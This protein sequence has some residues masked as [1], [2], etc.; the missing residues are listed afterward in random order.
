MSYVL[1]IKD[2]K[3]VIRSIQKMKGLKNIELEIGGQDMQSLV[4]QIESSPVLRLLPPKDDEKLDQFRKGLEGTAKKELIAGSALYPLVEFSVS[5]SAF[6]TKADPDSLYDRFAG[7]ILSITETFLNLMNRGNKKATQILANAD[8]HY[9]ELRNQ[10]KQIEDEYDNNLT[11]VIWLLPDFFVMFCRML[12]SDEISEK[13]KVRLVLT[14]LYIICPIDFIPEGMVGPVGYLDDMLITI[15]VISN[16]IKE[17]AINEA[18]MSQL[19]PGRLGTLRELD[20]YYAIIKEVL[21]EEL[22]RNII[23]RFEKMCR[24][25]EQSGTESDGSED[26]ESEGMARK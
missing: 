19:W 8:E 7:I 25:S 9:E 10:V 17:E 6:G 15:E 1:N 24:K 3:S 26:V 21:G 23:S 16:A 12:A 22:E 5:H 13:L 11:E 4:N 14:I 20:K 18:L 2:A